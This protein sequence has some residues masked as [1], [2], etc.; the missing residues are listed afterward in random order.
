MPLGVKIARHARERGGLLNTTLASLR[1]TGRGGFAVPA[2]T[3]RRKIKHIARANVRLIAR[4]KF[5]P[6]PVP[7][8]NVL[9]ACSSAVS[10]RHAIGRYPSPICEENEFHG[11]VKLV[12]A[13]NTNASIE[14][15]A[16]IARSG[17]STVTKAEALY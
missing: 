3:R 4:A 15:A 8:K 12:H 6:R 2:A 9:L 1:C 14:F 13:L 5:V 10:S 11:C 17:R 16:P 7:T